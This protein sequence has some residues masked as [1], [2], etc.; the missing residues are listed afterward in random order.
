[1]VGRSILCYL[2]FDDPSPNPA[3]IQLLEDGS[4]CKRG[5]LCLAILFH[6]TIMVYCYVYFDD[7]S[8]NPIT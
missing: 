5:Q 6:L 8:S 3:D 1:M 4:K 2:Y 7:P